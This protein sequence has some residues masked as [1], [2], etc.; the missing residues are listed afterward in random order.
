MRTSNVEMDLQMQTCSSL[1]RVYFGTA[2]R[3]HRNIPIF[4]PIYYYYIESVSMERY[5]IYYALV[6]PTFLICKQARGQLLAGTPIMF[7]VSLKIKSLVNWHECSR[8]TLTNL[9]TD[10]PRD[11]P[12]IVFAHALLYWWL[13]WEILIGI[14]IFKCVRSLVPHNRLFTINFN[15]MLITNKTTCHIEIVIHNV[16]NKVLMKFYSRKKRLTFVDFAR[17]PTRFRVI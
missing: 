13:W 8:V 16:S 17:Q 7:D 12:E 1:M 3:A 10:T 11:T 15:Y 4:E 2:G 9:S 5:K 6:Y 14:Y